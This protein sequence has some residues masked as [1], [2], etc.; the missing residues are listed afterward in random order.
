MASLTLVEV[1]VRS[2]GIKEVFREILQLW[3]HPSNAASLSD[4]RE[5]WENNKAE[6]LLIN[7]VKLLV[8]KNSKCG[9]F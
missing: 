8:Y 1:R 6:N 5:G 7:Y 9:R 2:V 3:V 4:Q